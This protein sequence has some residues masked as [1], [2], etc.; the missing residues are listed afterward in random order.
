M[1]NK[2]SSLAE[3]QELHRLVTRSFKERLALDLEEQVPTDAATL[4]ACIKFLKDNAISADP[5]TA[6]DLSEL[7][8]KLLQASKARGGSTLLAEAQEPGTGPLDGPW[9]HLQ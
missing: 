5:E 2:A 3:L 9:G 7:R 4:G 6:D 8:S 1:S